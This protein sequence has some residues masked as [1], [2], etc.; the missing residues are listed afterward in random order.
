MASPK[1]QEKAKLSEKD[2]ICD[3]M[4]AQKHMCTLYDAYA[5]ECATPNLRD[6]FVSLLR[7]E[8]QIQADLFDELLRRGWFQAAMADPNALQQIKQSYQNPPQQSQQA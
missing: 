2:I 3:S 4:N 8:H 7:D 1:K 6:E 5:C